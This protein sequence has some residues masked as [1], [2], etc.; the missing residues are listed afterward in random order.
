MTRCAKIKEVMNRFVIDPLCPQTTTWSSEIR[1]PEMAIPMAS[2]RRGEK[3]KKTASYS[4]FT[5]KADFFAATAFG[6]SIAVG[7]VAMACIK[8]QRRADR[9]AG[10][11]SRKCELSV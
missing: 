11:K 7:A 1:E 4:G 6:V 8:L 2:A 5:M 3:I 10:H 9:E